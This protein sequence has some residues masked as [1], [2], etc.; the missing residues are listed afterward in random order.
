M[1]TSGLRPTILALLS[2]VSIVMCCQR[3][4]KEVNVDSDIANIKEA[5]GQYA[6]T[7]NAGDFDGWISLWDDAGVQMPP[8]SPPLVGKAQITEG[9]KPSFEEMSLDIAINSIEEVRAHGDLGLTR[10]TYTLSATPKEGGERV[11]VMPN[12]KALTVWTR[13]PDGSWKILYDCFNS[14]VPPE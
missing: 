5:L 3:Q 10:C 8:D 9:N 7:C 14:N 12:G 13:Q 6:V 11:A 4:T 2:M 1:R